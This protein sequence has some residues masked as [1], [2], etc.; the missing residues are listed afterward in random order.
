MQCISW[1]NFRRLDH[2]DLSRYIFWGGL[3]RGFSRFFRVFR[4]RDQEINGWSTWSCEVQTPGADVSKTTTHPSWRSEHSNPSPRYQCLQSGWS[5]VKS[6]LGL[7]QEMMILHTR[8]YK[9]KYIYIYVY[10]CLYICIYVCMYICIYVYMY[11]CMK[12]EYAYMYDNWICIYD[13]YQCVYM[14]YIYIYDNHDWYLYMVIVTV[15]ALRATQRTRISGEGNTAKPI[16]AWSL[17]IWLLHLWFMI[18]SGQINHRGE[19]SNH[20]VKDNNR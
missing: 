20:V 8:M 11:I 10:I 14:I 9:Y 6:D 16:V 5:P 18:N 12:I 7:R 2:P 3:A 15:A 1:I 17:K 4:P 19:D 13:L